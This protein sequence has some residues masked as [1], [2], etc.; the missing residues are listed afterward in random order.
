MYYGDVND[1]TPFFELPEC[2]GHEP[3]LDDCNHK[4]LLR[5]ATYCTPDDAIG[6]ICEGTVVVL[7]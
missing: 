2:E 6:I 1:T 3:V 7:L 5:V 4:N